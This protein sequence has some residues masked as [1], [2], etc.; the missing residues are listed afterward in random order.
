M[1]LPHFFDNIFRGCGQ[2][3]RSVAS[4]ASIAVMLGNPVTRPISSTP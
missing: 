3:P 4:P 2:V 1:P